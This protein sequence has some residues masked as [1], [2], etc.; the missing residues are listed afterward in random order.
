[1]PLRCLLAAIALLAASAAAHAHLASDSYLRLEIGAAGNIDGRWDIA[2]RDL[3]VAVGLDADQDGAITWGELR[4]KRQAVEA[5]A[6]GRLTLISEAGAC[7]LV[8]A[9]LMVDYQPALLMR[10]CPLRP[11]APR[12]AA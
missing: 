12:A 2:L 6:L 3:D 5:Y 7:R 4:A 8:P 10:Y 11:N 9:A 1:M